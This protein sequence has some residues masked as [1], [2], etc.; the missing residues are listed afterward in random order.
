MVSDPKTGRVT[1]NLI[2]P[3]IF[4]RL[5]IYLFT[6]G[7]RSS[8]SDSDA[9][10]LSGVFDDSNMVALAQRQISATS[11]KSLDLPLWKHVDNELKKT[12]KTHLIEHARIAMG[13]VIG[14][15]QFGMVHEALLTNDRPLSND[16]GQVSH[17]KVAVKTLRGELERE[18]GGMGYRV[19]I[20]VNMFSSR[21]NI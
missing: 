8:C 12:I 2:N 11:S 9:S 7:T 19:N 13:K 3:S 20:Q 21:I 4:R 16:Y 17:T 1:Q 5:K 6:S 15:G 10:S 18:Y 14:K